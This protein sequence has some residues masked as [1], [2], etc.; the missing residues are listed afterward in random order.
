MLQ[1]ARIIRIGIATTGLVE[2]RIGIEIGI[3]VVEVWVGIDVVFGV[4]IL[5]VAR[6]P[7]LRRQLFAYAI[8]GFLS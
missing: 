1:V 8:L 3:D 6:N 7:S 4:L 2:V 5:D